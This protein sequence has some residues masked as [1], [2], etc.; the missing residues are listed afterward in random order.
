MKLVDVTFPVYYL[1]KRKPIVEDNVTFYLN[2]TEID[3]K[4][5]YFPYII[6]DKNIAGSTLATRRLKILSDGSGKLQKLKYCAFFL[7][8]MLKLTK[9][10]TWFVDS[11]GKIF[12]YKKSI[13]VPLVFKKIKHISPIRTGGALIEVESIPNKFKTLF[14]PQIEHKVAGLLRISGGYVLYGLYDKLY[15]KTTRMI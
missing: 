2:K 5:V 14:T 13:R 8:D 3:G 6:D 12:E 10:A 9:G 11:Y 1:G 7:G 15:D 4:V